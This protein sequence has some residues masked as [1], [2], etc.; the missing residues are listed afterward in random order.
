ML[1]GGAVILLGVGALIF[2][3]ASRAPSAPVVGSLEVISLPAGATLEVDGRRLGTTPTVVDDVPIGSTV[4]LRLL[5][6][7]HDVWERSER[8]DTAAR[9]KVNAQLKAVRGTLKVDSTPPGAEVLLDNR[10]IGTT[11]LERT[12]LDPFV[13]GVVEVRRQGYRP[14]REKLVWAGQRTA[15]LSFELEPAK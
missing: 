9:V 15:S 6:D 8:V 2:A 3:L 14:K 12:D 7:K 10:S 5:L 13:D 4:K 11:P 1:I